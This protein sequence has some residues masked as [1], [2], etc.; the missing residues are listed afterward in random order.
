MNNYYWNFN[1]TADFWHRSK[2]T[3]EECIEQAKIEAEDE[4]IVYIGEIEKFMPYID[5]DSILDKITNYA[6]DEHGEV[7]EGWLE[8][9]ES[10][11]VD[12]LSDD[13]TN[14]LLRWLDRHG[15]SPEFGNIKN[16]KAYDLKTGKEIKE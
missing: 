8:K 16:I 1:K 12:E 15:L 13:L 3:I 10:D 11:I 7:S 14:T 6:Y 9:V 2:N 4:S 5:G